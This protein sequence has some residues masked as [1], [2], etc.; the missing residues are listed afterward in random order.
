M[1]KKVQKNHEERV[2]LHYD[3]KSSE[4]LRAMS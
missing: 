3:I 4:T 2:R 1:N